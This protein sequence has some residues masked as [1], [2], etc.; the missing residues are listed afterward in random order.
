M[1]PILWCQVVDVESNDLSG[2]VTESLHPSYGTAVKM[3]LWLCPFAVAV[4]VALPIALA[5]AV[6]VTE[7]DPAGTVI[8]GG[9]KITLELSLAS[10]TVNPLDGAGPLRVK[11]MAMVSPTLT[12]PE[13]RL[14]LLNAIGTTIKVA[15]FLTPLTV[16]E[17]VTDC[18]PV[19]ANVVTVN[20]A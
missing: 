4:R 18:E 6:I 1:Q 8:V 10:V 20:V 12:D 9:S 14:I 3:T 16:A 7:G 11:V 17:I 15:L 13:S 2:R 19:T 5:V